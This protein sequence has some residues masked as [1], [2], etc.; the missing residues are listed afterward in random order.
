MRTSGGV[1]QRSRVCEVIPWEA[2]IEQLRF[3]KLSLRKEERRLVGTFYT[4][5]YRTIYILLLYR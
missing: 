3:R 5:R 1:E 4:L 2:G